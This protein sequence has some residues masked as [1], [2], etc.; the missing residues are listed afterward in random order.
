MSG[1]TLLERGGVGFRGRHERLVSSLK[2][3]LS[4]ILP[5]LLPLHPAVTVPPGRRLLT[6]FLSAESSERMMLF[7]FICLVPVILL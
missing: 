1:F 2:H 7:V 4:S 3:L 5:L 6:H